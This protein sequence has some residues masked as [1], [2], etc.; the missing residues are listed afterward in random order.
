MI[1][2]FLD[3]TG[4]TKLSN[5]VVD[6]DPSIKQFGEILDDKSL[7]QLV[8]EGTRG[9]N[10][11]DFFATNFLPRIN[12]NKIIPETSHHCIP[13]IEVDV[14]PIRRKQKHRKLIF[15]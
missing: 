2:T 14:R 10:T 5:R 4:K 6:T 11:L 13:R 7:V 15:E 9:R 1:S 8:D 3:G 12:K